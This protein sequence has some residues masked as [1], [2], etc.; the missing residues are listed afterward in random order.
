M[1]IYFYFVN[2]KKYCDY[3]HD[4]SYTYNLPHSALRHE[5]MQYTCTCAFDLYRSAYSITSTAASKTSD[6]KFYNIG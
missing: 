6:W 3:L 1:K 2:N 4:S 5:W